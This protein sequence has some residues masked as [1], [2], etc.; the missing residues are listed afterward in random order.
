MQAYLYQSGPH[1]SIY[2]LAKG[3]NRPA[4]EFL[5]KVADNQPEE[6]AKLTSLLDYSCAHGLPKNKQ[7]INTLGNGLFEFKTIGGLRLIWF[8]D[9]NRVILCTHGFVKKR[10][11]TPRSEVENAS[12]WKKDFEFSK[13]AKRLEMIDQR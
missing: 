10:Q 7:K 2:L 8:W 3:N 9:A 1:A 6:F 5:M 4:E 11:D 13:K 12:H